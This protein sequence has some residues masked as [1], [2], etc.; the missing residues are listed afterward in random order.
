MDPS[1]KP[2]AGVPPHEGWRNRDY[3][4]GD[5]TRPSR[6]RWLQIIAALMSLCMVGGMLW[7][8]ILKPLIQ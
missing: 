1:T 3:G 7:G 6:R 2:G 5:E 8:L 4:E